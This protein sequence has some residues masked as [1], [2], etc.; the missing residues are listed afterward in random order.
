M[1]ARKWGDEDEAPAAP[2]VVL[3]SSRD[4]AEV[5]RVAGAARLA[6]LAESHGWTVRLT[7]ALAE[8]P[9]RFYLNGR[10]AKA[11]HRL[12]SVVVRMVRGADR[13][14]AAWHGEDGAAWRFTVAY[15][16]VV[17]VWDRPGK[18][19]HPTLADRLAA[20]S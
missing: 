15:F 8:V 20:S 6:K 3:V 4:G 10:L 2:P 18:L 7:Y 17:R 1:P 12:A 5:P 9:E 11:A 19:G 13:G 16:G 14:W